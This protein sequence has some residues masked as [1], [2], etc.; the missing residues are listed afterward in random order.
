MAVQRLRAPRATRLLLITS[1]F[2]TADRPA[3]GIFVTRRL[4]G[5]RGV[6]VVA[7]RSY[8]GSRT[9]RFLRLTFEA[10]TARGAYHGVE[11]HFL[12]PAGPIGL[13]AARLRGV[14]LLVYAHGG[15][16]RD[17]AN[18]SVLHRALARLVARRADAVVT[19]SADTA[20][21]IEELG[22]TPI[23]TPPGVDLDRFRPSPRP[24]VRRVLYLGGR[25][26]HKGYDVA[27]EHADTL[28]G[29]GIQEIPPDQIPAVIAAHDVVLV[30]SYEEPYGL[31]AAEAIACGRWVVARA[32]GGLRSIVIDGV[33]GT[34]VE[35]GDF[36]GAVARVPDYDPAAVAAT[37]ARFDAR[38]ERDALARIWDELRARHGRQP[39]A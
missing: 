38:H 31:V 2:P 39:K 11:A 32:V 24:T 5:L 9:L 37:A 21:R 27:R 6:R 34:L 12:L 19:N 16:V 35:D 17:S 7:P 1:R 36:L 18:R 3:A 23:V 26:A 28:A 25:L 14:P 10:L 20:S 30:P 15:D 13:I 33:N 29:P 4:S 8:A 22:R